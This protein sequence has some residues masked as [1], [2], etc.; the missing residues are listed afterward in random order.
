[1]GSASESVRHTPSFQNLLHSYLELP[2][3]D[4]VKVH[5]HE[6]H[7]AGAL[8]PPS[9]ALMPSLPGSRA[10]LKLIAGY[11]IPVTLEISPS[12]F[13]ESQ[14]LSSSACSAYNAM[15]CMQ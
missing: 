6:A 8:P 9:N 15:L 4:T 13:H 1:M 2:S 10:L 11:Q 12:H 7:P 5:D 14:L 3:L